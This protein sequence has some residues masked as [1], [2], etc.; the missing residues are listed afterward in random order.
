MS[1]SDDHLAQQLRAWR[2]SEATKRNLAAYQIFS[3][4]EMQSLVD[5]RP[6]TLND[7]RQIKGF[8]AFKCEH[9]GAAIVALTSMAS[10][11]QSYPPRPHVQPPPPTPPPPPQYQ[12]PPYRQQ[13]SQLHPDVASLIAM[14]FDEAQ[15]KRA[16]QSSAFS[17]EH[18]LQML[19]GRQQE[20]P[21]PPAALSSGGRG[22]NGGSNSGSSSGGSSSRSSVVVDLLSDSDDELP[23]TRKQKPI[24]PDAQLGWE[25]SIV[26]LRGI[27]SARGVST[28]TCIEKRELVELL[29]ASSEP[30]PGRG[31]KRQRSKADGSLSGAAPQRGLT[32]EPQ[33][34]VEQS[35][36]AARVESGANIFL[37]GPAGVGKSFLVHSLIQRLQQAHGADGVAVT[38]S[39]GIA[40]LA[41]GGQTLHSWAGIGP[42]KDSIDQLVSRVLANEQATARW[43]ACVSLVVDEVS[44]LED[45]IITKLEAVARTVRANGQPFGGLQL[46]LVG[47]FF[48]LPPVELGRGGARFAFASPAWQTCGIETIA[49]T[50]IVRQAG[51]TPFISLLG[52][53]RRG[54]CT[55]ATETQLAACHVDVKPLPRD[56]ILPTRI[57]CVNRRVDEDNE[58]ELERLPGHHTVYDAIDVFRQPPE[59]EQAKEKLQA[60]LEGKAPVQL[61]LK[62][63]AQVVLTRNWPEQRLASGSR[64]VVL[65]F[66]QPQ[67]KQPQ[68]NDQQPRRNVQSL[69]VVRFDSGAE[70][71]IA[72]SPFTKGALQRL[73]LPLKLAWA[74]T[75]HKSQGMT[76]SRAIIEVGDAFDYGQVY[77]ALSR[78]SSLAGLWIRGGR[79][80]QRVIKAHPDV[81][82]FYAQHDVWAQPRSLP[83][84]PQ[85]SFSSASRRP[86]SDGS[87]QDSAIVL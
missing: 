69:P 2:K 37:T 40:A 30:P 24:R 17:L 55:A 22:G 74:C 58:V 46:L 29:S 43:R 65:R 84:R 11:R 60:D 14:G 23:T 15:A 34:N 16:L 35:A 70:V 81:L 27:L 31:M 18:A 42:G 77:V 53:V 68:H 32:N 80:T 49:L 8:G 87:S 33:L 56:G 71:E 73:Q 7:L 79:V 25:L 54:M 19:L 28:E 48:Q 45:A 1:S 5:A 62:V 78:V 85:P 9:Y 72:R 36:V 47:D 63:G 52:E 10:R 61:R 6:S 57:A 12:P 4:A 39:T 38:A 50:T 3:N 26:E 67:R 21:P 64:G 13:P 20:P 83:P 76:L 86:L 44:M 75:V 82:R 59:S 41:L 66:A 51:D